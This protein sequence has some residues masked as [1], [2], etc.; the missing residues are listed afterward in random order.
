MSRGTPI[1]N[2]CLREPLPLRRLHAKLA[3]HEVE[4][5]G[6]G[7]VHVVVL[8]ATEATGEHDVA[9]LRRELLV[10][11]VQRLVPGVVDR[12][13]RLV[14]GLPVRGV[15]AGDHGPGLVAEL[16]VLVLDDAGVGHLAGRVVHH[17]DA[18]VV[19]LVEH[20]ALEAQ[21]AVLQ[22]AE[23][24][25]VERVDGAAV[26]GPRRDVGLLGDELLVLDAA[27]HL[28]ALEYVGDHLGVAAHGDA[29]VAVVE[30]VVVVREAAGQTLDDARGQVP[31]VAAPLLLRVALHERLEDVAAHE[32]ER[33]LLEVGGLADALGGDLLGDSGA[34]VCRRDD[35]GP[36]PGERVHVERHVVHLAAEVGHGRVHV[37]VELGEAA[38]VVP[39]VPHRGVEDVGSVAVDVD[40]LDLLGVDVAGDV[41]AAVDDEDGLAGPARGVGEH[42][43]GQAGS[44]DEV[45][46]LGHAWAPWLGIM[47]VRL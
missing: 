20:L 10:L 7:L 36:H 30:V 11:P 8:V 21:A 22:R 25:V 14:A 41:V 12:V 16:E 35:A 32:G 27:A 29:L 19:G 47:L 39:H 37:V 45:V 33:L 28:D 18:L 4:R 40:A 43:S 23:L 1:S 3:A 24:E 34:G 15:L 5:G 46:V 31:A 13:V 38:H 42:G 6:D 2:R 9:L 44:D 17:G 26:D